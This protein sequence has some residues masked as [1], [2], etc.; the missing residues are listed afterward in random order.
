MSLKASTLV[1]TGDAVRE[2]SSRL[3]DSAVET[4]AMTTDGRTVS[5]GE[6]LVSEKSQISE[7][8]IIRAVMV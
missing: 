7:D 4:E 5:L 6:L 8:N 3:F 1:I 2:E